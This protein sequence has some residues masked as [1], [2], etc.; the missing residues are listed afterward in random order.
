MRRLSPTVD[1]AA[2]TR[3]GKVPAGLR[4]ITPLTG[5]TLAGERLNE[6]AGARA[7]VPGA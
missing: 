4:R 2:I 3:I 5:G 7:P 1:S 6:A